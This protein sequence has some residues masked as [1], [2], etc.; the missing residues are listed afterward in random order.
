VRGRAAVTDFKELRIIRRLAQNS[1]SG[2]R[3]SKVLYRFP[4]AGGS[5]GLVFRETPNSVYRVAIF[6]PSGRQGVA[7]GAV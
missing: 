5:D 1:A 7:A 2:D 4:E 3:Y 6:S